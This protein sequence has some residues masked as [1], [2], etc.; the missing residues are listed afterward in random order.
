MSK[1]LT[2]DTVLDRIVATK[3]REVE[4][5]KTL[6]PPGP[7]AQPRRDFVAG[8]RNPGPGRRAIIAEIKR[9]SPSAGVIRD[10]FDP[11]AIARAYQAAGAAAISVLT[12]AEFFQ[13]SLAVLAEVRAAVDLP[14]LR[15]D[16]IID[17]VQLEEAAAGADAVLLIARILD[18]EL[19]QELFAAARG[20]GLAVLVEVH[21]RHDL[22]RSLALTPRP[23]LIGVNNRN[24]A[25]F[26]VSVARTLDL[27]PLIPKEITVVSE[28]G[29]SDPAVLTQLS[30][31]GVR[32]FLIGTSLMR[33]PDPGVAL[34]KLVYND[35]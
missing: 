23:D 29:L 15:K 5:L 4:K 6:G 19:L 13:G 17:R 7:P 35:D 24:L 1:T 30:R 8:L 34:R 9:A 20:L 22:A 33:A 25:D 18:D 14:L 2:T 10:P 12:D 28:S 26:T 16:F 21:D 27:L 32:A 31:A 3:R 11:G